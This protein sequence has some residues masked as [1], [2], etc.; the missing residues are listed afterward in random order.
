MPLDGETAKLFL[1]NGSLMCAAFILLAAALHD[2]KAFKISNRFS[3]ALIALFPL[4]VLTAPQEIAWM[5]HV[6][7]AGIVF[8]IGFAMFAL[9]AFGGGD[10]K[11]LAVAA[12]WAGP[13]MVATLMVIT[14]MAGGVLALVFAVAALL[15]AGF[16]R[17][18]HEEGHRPWHKA[19]VPYGVAIACGGIAALV[20]MAQ[21]SLT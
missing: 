7:V 8:L 10:V 13:K 2:V 20:M 14:T 21:N 19:P 5:Q 3:L 17:Q 9:G 6:A 15:R 4:Y 16:G 18:H 11:M 1:H 12:L